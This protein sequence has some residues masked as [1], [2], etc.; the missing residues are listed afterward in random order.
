MIDENFVIIYMDNIFLFTKHLP[1]LRTNTN[2]FLYHLQENDLYLKP[3]KCEFEK[4]KIEWLGMVI[5][6]GRI[7]MDPGKLK[8]IR[9]W[10]TPTTVKQV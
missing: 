9:E 6:E 7:L 10:P 2:R 1:T 3:K 5:E 4:K 8:G